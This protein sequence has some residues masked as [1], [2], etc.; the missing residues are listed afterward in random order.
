MHLTWSIVSLSKSKTTLVVMCAIL[1]APAAAAQVVARIVRAADTPTPSEIVQARN[2]YVA[3][4]NAA[5]PDKIAPLYAG[6]ALV[7]LS[8]GVV[9]RGKTEVARYFADVL[10]QSTADGAVT[11]TPLAATTAGNLGSETGSF[12]ESRTTSTGTRVQVTGVYVIIYTRGADGRW[13]IAMEVRTSGD[14][15]ALV[16]W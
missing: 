14:S 1:M 7:I 13:R 15:R 5:E 3:A 2:Q 8:E 4:V 12:E 9:L 10:H 6:D 11:I 16:Q